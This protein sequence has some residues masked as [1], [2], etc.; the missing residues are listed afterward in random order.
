MRTGLKARGYSGTLTEIQ[1]KNLGMVFF[2]F[3]FTIIV[4]S[5]FVSNTI[6]LIMLCIHRLAYLYP[7][8]KINYHLYF[9]F[10][11]KTLL[12]IINSILFSYLVLIPSSPPLLFQS[13]LRV[14][15]PK[16][17]LNLLG[18]YSWAILPSS[19]FPLPSAKYK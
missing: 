5:H 1:I 15:S 9:I 8:A 2:G 12:L 10:I 13:F 19:T 14:R 17:Y 18:L 16:K 4:N 3:N 7:S 11:Q 6:S